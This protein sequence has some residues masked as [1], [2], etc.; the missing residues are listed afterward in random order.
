M[1]WART[2][3]AALLGR[4]STAPGPGAVDAPEPAPLLLDPGTRTFWSQGAA[5]PATLV[6]VSEPASTEPPSSRRVAALV[7]SHEL[8]PPPARP[9]GDPAFS[10]ALFVELMRARQHGRAFQLLAAD[11]RRSWGT[12]AAFA[13]RHRAGDAGR[14]LGVEVRAVR[15]LGSWID[16]DRQV[17]HDEVAELDVEYSVACGDRAV[18]V[19]RTVHLVAE[20]G[21]W[22]SLCYP[23][24]DGRRGPR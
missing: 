15:L 17:P 6:E 2:L 21:R 22:R 3:A 7:R 18:S 13:D 5:A 4:G 24:E 12:A 14:V 8:P 20:G 19:A 9:R 23:Q 11:C 16:P 10:E 1:A